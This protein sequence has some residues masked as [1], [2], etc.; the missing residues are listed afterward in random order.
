MHQSFFEGENEKILLSTVSPKF[1][2]KMGFI[3]ANAFI[4]YEVFPV[5][6]CKASFKN[7]LFS[8]VNSSDL[9]S[10]C[11]NYLPNKETSIVQQFRQGSN[12]DVQ[13]IIDI[14]SENK[15]FVYPTI[16]N[17]DHLLLQAAEIRVT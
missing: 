11:G 10:S 17:I 3:I 2:R 9:L 12:A 5:K 7:I 14:L 13:A 8:T 6:L 4:Y 1:L 15:I 16:E